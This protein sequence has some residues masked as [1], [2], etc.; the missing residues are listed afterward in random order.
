[1]KKIFPTRIIKPVE[2]IFKDVLSKP[3]IK[4]LALIAIAK[5][6]PRNLKSMR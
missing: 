3:K 2:E 6:E 4:T 1:M 5:Q